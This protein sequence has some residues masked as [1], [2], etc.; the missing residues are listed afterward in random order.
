M[1]N[2]DVISEK[3]IKVVIGVL[4]VAFL[5][6]IYNLASLMSVAPT[7]LGAKI[8]HA[9]TPQWITMKQGLIGAMK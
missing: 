8:A 3:R 9:P 6:L 5:F 7:F 4:M 2:I 1:D